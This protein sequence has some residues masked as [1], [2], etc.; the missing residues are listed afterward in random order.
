MKVEDNISQLKI[1]NIMIRE[2][3]IL[4]NTVNI[5]LN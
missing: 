4:E 3:M 1:N 2:V 5:N